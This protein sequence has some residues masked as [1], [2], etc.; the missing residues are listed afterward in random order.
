MD[1]EFERRQ[2]A[3][4][5]GSASPSRPPPN[6][7]AACCVAHEQV[8]YMLNVTVTGTA[9]STYYLADPALFLHDQRGRTGADDAADGI[10]HARRELRRLVA[11]IDE[12]S[13]LG[14]A[15]G[16]MLGWLACFGWRFP[17]RPATLGEPLQA[18]TR[19]APSAPGSWSRHRA[20]TW[21][22]HRPGGAREAPPAAP[23]RGLRAERHPARGAADQRLRAAGHPPRPRARRR[24]QLPGHRPGRPR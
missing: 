9:L 17:A 13:T 16:R 2:G 6:R 19:Q 3:V 1:E 10:R 18:A 20:S 4:A 12:T 5:A 24:G 11:D 23:G 21:T 14:Q 7:S 8:A 15:R 22:P